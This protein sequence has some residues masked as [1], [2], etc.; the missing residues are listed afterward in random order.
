MNRTDLFVDNTF[1]GSFFKMKSLCIKTNNSEIIQYLLEKF[2]NYNM[3]SVYFS[4]NKF[5]TYRNITIHY[6]G[7]Q[8]DEFTYRLSEYLTE[9]IMFFYEKA[10]LRRLLHYNYFYFD[11][12]EQNS[13]L[14][15]VHTIILEN[16]SYLSRDSL[17]WS[18]VLKYILEHHS[19]VLTGFVNFRLKDY[20]RLLDKILDETVS[21]YIIEREYSEFIHLLKSYISSQP[22]TCSLVHVIYLNG[23]SILLDE[24]RKPLP[25]H[26]TSVKAKYLSDITFSS[27]DYALNT[28]LNLLPNH[29]EVHLI[30]PEDEFI[31]TLRLIFEDRI[32]FC[33]DC[34]ICT[35]YKRFQNVTL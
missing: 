24:N 27:N 23:E 2:A 26:N 20:T 10:L 31:H 5:R 4:E 8:E 9:C 32:H 19:L 28:L 7:P 29:L 17:I 34:N 15:M 35:T 6:T 30:D 1:E 18:E 11:Q 33:S 21:K 14:K 25:F 12:E 3:E 16:D 22:S 13:I